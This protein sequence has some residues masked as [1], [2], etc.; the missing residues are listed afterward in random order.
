MAAAELCR[1]SSSTTRWA[2]WVPSMSSEYDVTRCC[3]NKLPW[4]AAALLSAEQ[5]VVT[6]SWVLAA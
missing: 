6:K 2:T 3:E 5:V 1:P 4:Y